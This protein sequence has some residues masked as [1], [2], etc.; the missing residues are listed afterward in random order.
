[1]LSPEPV[2]PDGAPVAE[3]TRGAR[4]VQRGKE[5]GAA[6]RPLLRRWRPRR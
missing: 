1:V 4:I 6:R 2:K 5:K 3:K